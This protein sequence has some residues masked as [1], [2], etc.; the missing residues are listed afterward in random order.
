MSRADHAEPL[1]R[2]QR[3][4]EGW[5]LLDKA[6]ADEVLLAVLAVLGSPAVLCSTQVDMAGMPGS[7]AEEPKRHR[8]HMT[9]QLHRGLLRKD[10]KH[11]PGSRQ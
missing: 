1:P 10:E 6:V 5:W 11:R 7:L 2:D 4:W 9:T 3:G 8:P